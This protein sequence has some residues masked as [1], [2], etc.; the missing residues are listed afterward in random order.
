MCCLRDTNGTMGNSDSLYS[1]VKL[2]F[3]IST[4]C[5]CKHHRGS[6]V[7]PRMAS[8]ACHPCYPG[9]PSVCFGS[10]CLRQTYQPSPNVHRVG[11]SD[12]LF[13]RLHVGSLSLQPAGL[14]D[15]LKE[16]LSGNLMLQVTLNTSLK[17]RGRTTELPPS[18]FNRQVT[19]FTRHTLQ[20]L[21]WIYH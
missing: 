3:L 21:S 10:C 11:D 7:L 16:P 17:L 6:P 20:S 2:R 15:S 4:G 14:L 1:P 19:R 12:Y 9:S 8:P 18:D 13:T 5:L